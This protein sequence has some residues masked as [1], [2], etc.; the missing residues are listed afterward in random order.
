MF[1]FKSNCPPL[2]CRG[3]QLVYGSN[4][5][6]FA[7]C[8]P[9]ETTSVIKQNQCKARHCCLHGVGDIGIQHVSLSRLLQT[10]YTLQ[11]LP[12]TRQS[13]L[14]NITT[15]QCTTLVECSGMFSMCQFCWTAASFLTQLCLLLTYIL[16]AEHQHISSIQPCFKAQRMCHKQ[17]TKPHKGAD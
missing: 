17:R 10:Y 3:N 15:Q 2:S 14:S 7:K 5:K 6:I 9:S 1:I 12:R 11:E 4:M 8:S 13:K 16:K